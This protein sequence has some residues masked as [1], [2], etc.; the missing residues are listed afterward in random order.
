[1]KKFMGLFVSF[2]LI[3][4]VLSGCSG[5]N[6]KDAESKSDNASSEQTKK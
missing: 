5:S 1:M 3:I 2:I 6:N 4:G